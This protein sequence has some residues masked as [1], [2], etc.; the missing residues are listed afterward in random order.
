MRAASIVTVFAKP[1]TVKKRLR[2]KTVSF[3]MLH[4]F[5]DFC[6]TYLSEFV[7]LK[8]EAKLFEANFN[9]RL[10]TVGGKE[11]S[12]KLNTIILYTNIRNV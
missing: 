4:W 8:S 3:R 10:N 2:N 7:K 1:E 11:S 12:V 6:A 9:I 5:W